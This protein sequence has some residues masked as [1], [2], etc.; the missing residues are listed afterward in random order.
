MQIFPP[1]GVT[2][3]DGVDPKW[4]R[5]FAWYPVEVDAYKENEIR[6]GKMRYK[7][8][9]EWVECR[10]SPDGNPPDDVSIMKYRLPR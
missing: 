7:V 4:T 6:N 5:W 9:L 8:W 2:D 1:S 10:M 3:R